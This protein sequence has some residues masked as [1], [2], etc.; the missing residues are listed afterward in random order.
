MKLDPR[1]LRYLLAIDTHGTFIRAA[2]AEGISQPALSNKI[3][4][5]ERHLGTRVVDRGRHGA[6]L[7][8]QG[9]L[10]LRHARAIDAVVD[11]AEAEI[12]EALRGDSGPLAIGGTPISMLELVPRALA[13][14]DTLNN[15]VRITLTEADD[16]I[17]LDK[18]RAG[19]IDL[20]LGGMV[21]DQRGDDILE[22]H[23][24]DFPLQAVVGRANP[25][26]RSDAVALEDMIGQDW[27]LP[28]AGSV[29]RSYVDA[30]F[31]S[32]GETMPTSYWSCSSM[33][34]LKTVVQHTR[35]V[36]LMPLHAFALEAEK[37]VL[38]GLR[39]LGASSSRKMNI[40]RLQHL[41]LSSVAE[42]F[43]TQLK[44]VAASLDQRQ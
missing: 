33:H 3:G 35:R 16:D 40:L 28:A 32:A 2:D 25:L 27:A 39:L 23:L 5:L 37:G 34:G 31:V 10:L 41:P 42:V 8:A 9:R 4:L 11:R 19:E 44:D 29:I 26:W 43:L 12:G 24:I 22:E 17:L 20:M 21:S 14:L 6:T 1:L 15:R 18:L 36:S 30:I 13:R 38:K 7:N